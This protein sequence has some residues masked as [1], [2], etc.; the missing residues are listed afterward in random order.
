VPATAALLVAWR[1]AEKPATSATAM[2][3]IAPMLTRLPTAI[4][5]WRAQLA[6]R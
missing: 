4:S 3:P 1:K 5:M 6:R 2:T